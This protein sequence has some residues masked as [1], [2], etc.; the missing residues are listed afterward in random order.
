MKKQKDDHLEKLGERIR[1]AKSKTEDTEI[2]DRQPNSRLIGLGMR[3]AL[4]MI[5][6]IGVCGFIGWYVDKFFDSK[7]WF[8]LVFLI[9]G[10]AAGFKS[11]F[12]IIKVIEKND[13]N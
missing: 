1:S 2:V 3:V 7:P 10:I 6:S 4:E 13:I 8:L 11:V 5:A 12:K 9:L